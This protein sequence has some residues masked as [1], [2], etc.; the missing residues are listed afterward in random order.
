MTNG[1]AHTNELPLEG[2][3]PLWGSLCMFLD[4]L[5][6]PA[7]I[8]SST[9]VSRYV[10]PSFTE[11][12]Q[13]PGSKI[14]GSLNILEDEY[15]KRDPD[16]ASHLRKAFSGHITYFRDVRAPL[17]EIE[18]RYL[19]WHD[20]H[21]DEDLYQDIVCFPLS[22]EDFDVI[23]TLFVTTRVFRSQSAALAAK[24]YI[25]EHWFDDFDLTAIAQSVSIS[26]YHLIRVFKRYIG[27][28]PYGYFQGVKVGHIAEALKNPNMTIG[29]AFSSCGAD[30]AGACT[31]AFRRII[32][33]TPSEYRKSLHDNVVLSQSGSEPS[34]VLLDERLLNLLALPIQVFSANGSLIFVNEAVLHAWS[35]SDTSQII[36]GFNLIADKMVN[37]QYGLREQIERSFRGEI[38]HIEDVRVPL[39]EFWAAY[40]KRSGGTAPRVL[41]TDIINFPLHDSSGNLAYLMSIFLESRSYRGTK[42]VAKATE[43][44][45]NHWRDEYDGDAVSAAAGVSTA[46]LSRLFREHFGITPYAYHQE[47]KIRGLKEALRNPNLSVASAFASCGF[48]HAGNASRFF[49]QK[50]GMTP[51]QFRSS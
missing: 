28:T 12:F 38:V 43:Y 13:I 47:A 37:D 48:S 26:R 23:V 8:F 11:C 29:E 51:S 46:H 33:M 21:P 18:N 4:A 50:T 16:M 20:N 41:Y 22:A 44:L 1:I 30:Y 9:G 10:N 27:M 3:I 34:P 24:E 15:L 49:K 19:S 17:V 2:R 42:H 7:E 35:V 25:D 5:P 36:G 32:G 6:I 31:D 14:V 40:G 45:D 39:E